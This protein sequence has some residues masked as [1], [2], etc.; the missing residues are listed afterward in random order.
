VSGHINALAISGMMMIG[1]F[2]VFFVGYVIVG[3]VGSDNNWFACCTV[4]ANISCDEFCWRA[5]YLTMEC[6]V[7]GVTALAGVGVKI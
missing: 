1:I 6:G 3:T 7:L 2:F 5:L 4:S